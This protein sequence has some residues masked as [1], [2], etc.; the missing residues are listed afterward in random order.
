MLRDIF[1]PLLAET[2]TQEQLET[3][4]KKAESDKM[5]SMRQIFGFYIHFCRESSGAFENLGGG[6]NR[7]KFP[8]KVGLTTT[9]DTD[10]RVAQQC[11]Q[12][13]C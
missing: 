10:A 9:G 6:R 5:Q 12:T 1:Q 4:I 3:R 11:K 7:G 13:C 8:V 2:Y